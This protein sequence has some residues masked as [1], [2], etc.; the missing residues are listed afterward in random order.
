MENKRRKEKK[1]KSVNERKGRED[2]MNEGKRKK[3]SWKEGKNY[4]GRI[5]EKGKRC[6]RERSRNER[7]SR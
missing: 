5:I 1:V 7:N 4:V 3:R 6:E 2:G